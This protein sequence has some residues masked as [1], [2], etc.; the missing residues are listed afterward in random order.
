MVQSEDQLFWPVTQIPSLR[1]LVITGNPFAVSSDAG[2]GYTQTLEVLLEQKGG[3]LINE[4]LNPPTYL[5]RGT[6]NKTREQQRMLM[7]NMNN[8]GNSNALVQV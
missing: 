4:T 8:Y 6:G 1:Y 2:D 7:T 3:Q 5:R